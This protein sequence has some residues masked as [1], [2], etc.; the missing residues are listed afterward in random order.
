MTWL[1]VRWDVFS[2]KLKKHNP[3]RKGTSC[4]WVDIWANVTHYVRCC[5]IYALGSFELWYS[6][7][8]RC[9]CLIFMRQLCQ[10]CVW[11]LHIGFAFIWSHKF[12]GH[13]HYFDLKL[14]NGFYLC[15]PIVRCWIC[16]V[17][18]LYSEGLGSIW[19]WSCSASCSALFG[20]S[21]AF[22]LDK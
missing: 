1:F 3:V 2:R 19:A 22:S 18:N 5:F 14:W 13:L 8:H 20:F 11:H 6:W 9:P 21:S 10:F 12:G 4:F 17:A 16:F 7:A 15:C